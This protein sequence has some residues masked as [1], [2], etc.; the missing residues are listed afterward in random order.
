MVEELKRKRAAIKG[1]LTRF[2]H[3][4]DTI[5]TDTRLDTSELEC[6][7][8]SVDSLL[9][10]FNDVQLKIEQADENSEKH[11]DSIH[12]VERS[13]FENAYYKTIS[14]AKQLLNS[15][16][17]SQTIN[18]GYETP[19]DTFHSLIHINDMLSPIQKFHYLRLSLKGSAADTV[20]SLEISSQNYLVAWQLLEERYEN[21][22]ILVNNHIKALFDL[23]VIHREAY[24]SLRQLLDDMQKHLRVLEVLKLPVPQW[25]SLLIYLIM[26][27]LGNTTRKEWE[28]RNKTQ[29]LPTMAEFTDFLKN[30]CRNL[31]S[32]EM[33]YDKSKQT[34]GSSKHNFM[35]N[36]SLLS[37]N[38]Y[39]QCTICK[40]ENTIYSCP[41]F[42]KF[43]P[44]EQHVISRI[45][46][47][48][49]FRKNADDRRQG[50]PSINRTGERHHTGGGSESHDANAAHATQVSTSD[51]GTVARRNHVVLA[52]DIA[53]ILLATAIVDISDDYGNTHEC[54]VLLDSGSTSHF[55][56]QNLCDIL[57]L[58]KTRINFDIS[59]IGQS[60]MKRNM[61]FHCEGGHQ[62]MKAFVQ[63]HVLEKLVQTNIIKYWEYCGVQNKTCSNIQYPN[64]ALL[65]GSNFPKLNVIKFPRHVICPYSTSIQLH[66][67]CDASEKAYEA[68]MYVRSV[69]AQ[70]NCFVNVLCA[71]TRVAPLK[72]V[73]IPRLELCGALLLAQP[74]A[75]LKES[76]KINFES[77]HYWCDSQIVI[78]WLITSPHLLK[79]SLHF[80]KCDESSLTLLDSNLNDT[81]L[82]GGLTPEE[83]DSALIC[84][85]KIVQISSFSND[86]RNLSLNGRVD[87]K[88]SLLSLS[89]YSDELIRVGGRLQNSD[90]PYD[91]KHPYILPKNHHLS[92]SIT[93]TKHLRLK[94]IGPQGLLSSIRERFWPIGGKGL[95]R[96]TVRDCIPC[97]FNGAI[98]IDIVSDLTTGCFLAAFRRFPSRRGSYSHVVSDNGTIFVVASK[99]LKQFVLNQQ[100]EIS[101]RLATDGIKWTFIPPLSPH[102]GG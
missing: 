56:S 35:K 26:S 10:K 42:N 59:G 82:S 19:Q 9:K 72:Q 74:I 30:K 57:H 95:V 17:A 84:I 81:E 22:Q 27:K 33:N 99:E 23:P 7:L 76:I 24:S 67:F 77:T 36:K 94:H 52:C 89:I 46:R 15:S 98:H 60:D 16:T 69:D 68:I 85:V 96:K 86:Y 48:Y 58:H 102:F 31:E 78:C 14:K 3:Y 43:N 75:K 64:L 51:G 65:K 11:I 37:T 49:I 20:K 8:P 79:I 39:S 54:R 88:S 34:P 1:S 97:I 80:P 83:L 70:G 92:V 45:T 93:H 18:I 25:D 63:T 12:S 5:N 73:T 40:R 91:K 32:F 38:A 2:L 100:S 41:E 87:S 44:T 50:M 53:D 61:D 62:I 13:K 47:Y 21:K 101:E 28:M 6:R 29:E 55:I 66:G 90:Y 71:K 4:F